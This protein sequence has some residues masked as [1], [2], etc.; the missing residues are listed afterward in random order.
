MTTTIE[1]SFYPL[2]NDYPISVVNFL[3]KLRAI[4]DIE[5]ETNGMSTLIIGNYEK[6]WPRLGAMMQEKLVDDNCIFV[7]KIAPG[8]R[9]YVD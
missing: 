9:E 5:M 1:I 7:L 3:Q 4:P 8:R 6:L 2:N